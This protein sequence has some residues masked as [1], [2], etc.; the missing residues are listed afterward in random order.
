M[1]G[2]VVFKQTHVNSTSVHKM[3]VRPAPGN[4]VDDAYIGSTG[5]SPSAWVADDYSRMWIFFNGGPTI[6]AGRWATEISW[7]SG[8]VGERF[9][10]TFITV[11]ASPRGQ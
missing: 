10:E 3:C 6:G 5:P 2:W 7:V 4:C 11:P 9:D 1:I 8:G